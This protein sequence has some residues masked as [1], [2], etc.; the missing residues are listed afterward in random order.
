MSSKQIKDLNV[1]NENKDVLKKPWDN[2]FITRTGK[3]I[4]TMT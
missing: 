2:S 3:A 1:K 4:L